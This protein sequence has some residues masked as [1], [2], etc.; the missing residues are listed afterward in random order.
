LGVVS[1]FQDQST[2]VKV[3]LQL[4]SVHPDCD[5][6]G[7]TSQA[8]RRIAMTNCRINAARMKK[9]FDGNSVFV[10]CKVGDV[11]GVKVSKRQ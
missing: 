7:S 8:D 9:T 3:L 2:I 6:V 11:I 1:L 10:N 5:A 4:S